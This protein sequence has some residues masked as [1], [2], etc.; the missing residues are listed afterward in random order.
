[1]KRKLLLF[2]IIGLLSI[3]CTPSRK[4]VMPVGCKPPKKVQYHMIAPAVHPHEKRLMTSKVKT[5]YD[6]DKRERLWKT[7]K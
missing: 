4:M 7:G 2:G 6:Y 3:S 1:M 5:K